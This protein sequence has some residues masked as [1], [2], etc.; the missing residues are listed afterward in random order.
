MNNKKEHE[1]HRLLGAVFQQHVP[2]TV[3]ENILER[4]FGIK[5]AQDGKER[6]QICVIWV[7]EFVRWH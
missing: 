3:R 1:L 2:Q 6:L 7:R 4:E 5:L